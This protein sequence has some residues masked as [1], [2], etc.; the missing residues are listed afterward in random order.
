MNWSIKKEIILVFI[1]AVITTILA[2]PKFTSQILHVP[3]DRVF[4]GMTTYFE[5]FYYY[6]DQFY[7]G[8][9]GNWLTENRFS[10][11]HFSPT[12]VY[13][14]HILLGKIG[15]WL[16]LEA[17]Q[18][19]NYF[20]ILFKFLFIIISYPIIWLLFSKSFRLRISTFMVYLYSTALPGFAIHNGKII[21]ESAQDVFRTGNRIMARF[22]TSPNG[23]LTN[24]L[25]LIVFLYLLYV[26]LKSKTMKSEI[27]QKK[28][29][30]FGFLF[31][32]LF[33]GTLYTDIIISDAFIGAVLLG[34]FIILLLI[35]GWK[36]ILTIDRLKFK[37]L[38][39]V[40]SF[41]YI[42][43]AEKIFFSVN[44]D[45]V[46]HQGNVWDITQYLHQA[47]AI[48]VWNILQGFGLQLP[49][50]LGG[51]FLVLRKKLKSTPELLALIITGFG[52]LGY[53]IPLVYQIPILG[54][55]FIFSG[56]YIFS[57]ALAVNAI[58]A[59]AKSIN[60]KNL[61]LSILML[62]LAINFF[63]FFR[64]WLIYIKVPE[65]PELNF[66]Y[67]PKELY[68]GMVFLR[69][70]EPLDGN[71]LASPRTSIDLMIPGLAGRHTYS[72]HFL[73]T[74]NSK[75]KDENAN[76]FFFKWTDR[77]GTRLFLKSN[78]I[79]FIVISKYLGNT[80]DIKS[81]YPFLKV[82][83]ENPTV[84]IFRYDPEV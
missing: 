45:P 33:F 2:T 7:Q 41:I 57:A 11:E 84:S 21:I 4:V 67:V 19:Y 73:T 48:G 46:Y 59:I 35:S 62:Y 69:T 5:D 38:L 53:V 31:E 54:F 72:G 18:S 76:N 27:L 20:G 80:E 26:F 32:L 10:V 43:T 47:K 40:F 52:L 82:V 30:S 36:T 37:I 50:F 70:A 81:Y 23:M 15:G 58:D 13:F 56:T 60:R 16:G 75:I 44:A 9:H 79:R 28:L 64:S 61:Y 65:V 25:F 42:I 14:N 83:F 22:G 77:P 55:R 66:T 24:L 29:L 34:T 49:F 74:Y 3:Q 71:V 1:I 6:L 12:L 63:T 17:F 8:A 78:N 51:Y 68:A 39:L